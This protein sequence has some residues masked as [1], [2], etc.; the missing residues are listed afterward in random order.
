MLNNHFS[1]LYR[2]FIVVVTIFFLSTVA[3]AATYYVSSSSGND[4]NDGLSETT[5]WQ[6]INKVNSIRFADSS[7]ILFKRGDIF[8]GEISFSATPLGIT[9]GAYGTAVDNPVIAGSVVITGWQKTTHPALNAN[10]VWEANVSSLLPEATSSIDYLFANGELM[11]IARYPNVNSPA[12]KNWLQ[13][14][15]TVGTDAFTDPKLAASGKPDNY[16]VGATLRIRNYSWIFLTRKIIGYTAA[17]GQI[18]AT[19][20]STQLPEWG[21]F[22]D[23]KLEEL[24]YPGEWYY[25]ATVK[26]VYFYPQ[27]GAD[28][29]TLLVEGT[30]YGTGISAS[31]G[32]NQMT[33]E[34]LTFRHFL[35]KGLLIS[36]SDSV[37]VRQCHFEHNLIGIYLYNA[38]QAVVTSN[39]LDHQLK[40]TIALQASDGFDVKGSVVEKNIITNGAL[41]RLYGN[42]YDG[43]YGGVGIV[44]FGKG[45]TIRQNRLENIGWVGIYA[46]GEGGHLIENNV[47]RKALLIL[48]DGGAISIG[49]SNNTIR[50][51]LLFESLGNI[52]ADSNGCMNANNTPCSHHAAYG[53]GIG[54]DQAMIGNV[55]EGN[56]VANNVDIGIRFNS[57]TNSILKNNVL[58]NNE[59]QLE[60]QDKHGPSANNVMQGN[61]IFS[62]APF[63]TG[64]VLTLDIPTTDHGPADSN[65]YCNP[66][67]EVVI[68]R[69]TNGY[70]LANYQGQ[71][72]GKEVNSTQCNLHFQEYLTTA[73]GANL[74]VN[75]T[76]DSNVQNWSG[77][78]AAVI[79]YDSAQTLLNGG[80]L[81]AV[82]N[83]TTGNATV[84]T[85]TAFNL[86][87]NQT[88]RIKFSVVGSGSGTLHL[89]VNDTSLVPSVI[90]TER[91]FA[92]DATRKDY[93]MVFTSQVS[94]TGGKLLFLSQN[95]DTYPYWL[96]NFA[97]EPVTATPIDG[98]QL[99]RL[100]YNDTEQNPKTIDLEG[101]TYLVYPEGNTVT[102][103]IALPAF[104]SK[105]LILTSSSPVL[106]NLTKAGTGTGVVTGPAGVGSG[107]QCGMTCTESYPFGAAI[108]LTAIPDAGSAFTGWTG[109]GCADTFPITAN[110][111]CIATFSPVT[112]Q[113]LT[114]SKGGTGGGLITGTGINC[115]TDCTES[116]S[117][118]T[119][120]NLTVTPDA[121]STFAGWIGAGCANSVTI[122]GNMNCTATFSSATSSYSLTVAASSEGQVTSLPA[123]IDCG[124]D[125]TQEY[126]SNTMV[127][128]IA[129]P[130]AGYQFIGWTGAC[131][132]SVT[133]VVT[134]TL[135]TNQTC[136]ALFALPQI[137]EV[138]LTLAPPTYG[139]ITSKDGKVN[140]EPTQ[141]ICDFIYPRGGTV[142]L[143]ATPDANAIFT[144]W[145]G[146]CS[147][148]G[149]TNPLTLTLWQNKGCAV[150]F[151]Q[152]TLPP[153]SLKTLTISQTGTGHGQVTGTPSGIDCGTD[154]VQEYPLNTE[155]T[156]LATP[157]AGSIFAGWTGNTQCANTIALTSDL[158]CT[159]IFNQKEL[160]PPPATFYRLYLNIAGIGN[161]TVSSSPTGVNCGV[162]C[163]EYVSGTVVTL[164][165]TPDVNSTFMGWSGEP[166]ASSFR[167][168]ENTNC[169]AT[170]NPV[171]SPPPPTPIYTLTLTK[172]GDGKGQ[173]NST[174]TGIECGTTCTQNFLSGTHLTLVATPDVGSTFAGWN[175]DHC[176]DSFTIL[177]QMNC[178]ATFNQVVSPPPP[179]PATFYQLYLNIAGTGLGTVSGHPTGVNCGGNCM[180]YPSGISVALTAT[181]AANSTFTGWSGEHCAN[182]FLLVKNTNCTAT[183][184]QQVL[185]PPVPTYKMQVGSMGSGTGQI[186]VS[187]SGS[188]C[189]THCTQYVSGTLITLTVIPNGDS[190]FADWNGENCA[191]SVTLK[192]DMNC[193]ATFT[194]IPLPPEPAAYKL[195]IEKMGNGQGEV[196]SLPKG[197][198][199]GLDCADKYPLDTK[200]TFI[201]TPAEGS[202]FA[203]WRGVGCADSVIVQGDMT[204]T[205][206]FTQLPRHTLT[207]HQAGINHGKVFSN[208]SGIDCGEDCMEDYLH[209]TMVTLTAVPAVGT[210]FVKWTDDCQDRFDNPITLKMDAAKMCWA[211]FEPA[212]VKL[213]FTPPKDGTVTSSDGRIQCGVDQTLCSANY[214][215]GDQIEL[216]AA[217]V[218]NT[219]STFATW[220]QDCGPY[221]S[222]NPIVI[223]IQSPWI[224]TATFI[225]PDH[226]TECFEKQ[227]GVMTEKGCLPADELT[228][229]SSSGR[230]LQTARMLGGI[231]KSDGPFKM[232]DTVK[233]SDPIVTA[234]T[235]KV[236][237]TDIGKPAE[238]IVSG[239]HTADFYPDG[240]V[241]YTLT[242][243]HSCPLGWT[244]Q[245]LP[246]D[247]N[248][249]LPLLSE[250]KSLK[251][252]PALPEYYTIYMYSGHFVYPGPLEIYFGYR[253][254]NGVDKGEMVLN[255]TPISVMI[256]TLPQPK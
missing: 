99:A 124:N 52:E 58:Y 100:V 252:V 17:T 120:V 88:Y 130:M 62:L 71:F 113:L 149:G 226:E 239:I 208:P 140:C 103:S 30:T 89:R 115:G 74:I 80:S 109:T 81:K 18:T 110:M 135:T 104:S 59:R 139:T 174:P 39:T 60:L 193:V 148:L 153:S 45:Y 184:N 238:I 240:F 178:T 234:A 218:Q 162:N 145:G 197:I 24:D 25:D 210:T 122:T 214:H 207:I 213:T 171:V 92:Y 190:Y 224:C 75:P 72:L 35:S 219:D 64:T 56:T 41:Y 150:T 19:G 61:T 212:V 242:D 107:I 211:L 55:F 118:G 44:A 175:G 67:S 11:T 6:S 146:D 233:L 2:K 163:T 217:S 23:D 187:P 48:N 29:N 151:T 114:V 147:N 83:G 119:L 172:V 168:T 8:R 241:W 112:T 47:I 108:T 244:V 84:V 78:G 157:D 200:I 42:R 199:C 231:S 65:H 116:Y 246:H 96:D 63:Q 16:W 160:P 94:T 245:I 191:P 40:D 182:S 247:K 128:L 169:T 194:K 138:H 73:T 82:Y 155:V 133:N 154:C 243:C 255:A 117:S 165:A 33:V 220:G 216:T 22:L 209:N 222:S 186:Q 28:P 156:L 177:A 250:W 176:A 196:T 50:G 170:F 105:I 98:K 13:V 14:G 57:Y 249:G 167:L 1:E 254:T 132:N 5:A 21:Y 106:L 93:E 195:V 26:K 27:N 12:E 20:L 123:G 144:G 236:E 159:A 3:Q 87:A 90:L 43:G 36:Q 70:S 143:V 68:K 152:V 9:V 10:L 77:A 215:F 129:T 69:T 34:N 38:T 204:C 253:L 223:S 181:P 51:N 183:F 137:Q 46:Q 205:A 111:D 206:T 203:G 228:V 79:S 179:L 4:T 198:E 66:Y 229:E 127:S 131:Q 221:G 91:D 202:L 15:A 141:L 95:F 192:E 32:E 142:E 201:T 54:A 227:K 230:T 248:T 85:K 134:L 166:C 126:A 101:K 256:E 7:V 225:K 53:M 232:V 102:G 235:L 189:G 164:T 251:T 31:A 161:G 136:G 173:V 188:D 158:T 37:T 185:P 86:V 121:N 237:P 125:C 180:E 49:S 76:F 97:L